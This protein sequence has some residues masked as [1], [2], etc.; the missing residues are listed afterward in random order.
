[1]GWEVL[2]V[3][4]SVAFS[5]WLGRKFVYAIILLFSFLE[6]CP[7]AWV[8]RLDTTR[9]EMG[10]RISG[11]AECWLDGVDREWLAR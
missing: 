6:G 11:N 4:C 3:P 10:T 1:M 2:C 9:E 7:E 5:R 8:L